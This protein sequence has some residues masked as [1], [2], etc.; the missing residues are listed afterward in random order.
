[1]PTS[2]VI[3]EFFAIRYSHAEF[4][5]RPDLTHAH[6]LQHELSE[7][8]FVFVECADMIDAYTMAHAAIGT[9]IETGPLKGTSQVS[10]NVEVLRVAEHEP[11]QMAVGQSILG[12]DEMRCVT[13][14]ITGKALIQ[15]VPHFAQAEL[16]RY[17][18]VNGWVVPATIE[19]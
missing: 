6:M 8:R 10:G 18:P 2:K 17:H 3:R 19:L 9:K 7:D 15:G 14:T 11:V 1:M 12:E 16:T 4:G 13:M 5:A